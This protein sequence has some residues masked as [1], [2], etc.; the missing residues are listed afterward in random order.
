M[1]NALIG[2]IVAFAGYSV[3]N[4]SQAGRKIGLE[5]ADKNR[6]RGLGTER[7]PECLPL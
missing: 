1:K 2:I 4:Y 6:R 7:L 3:L 5:T